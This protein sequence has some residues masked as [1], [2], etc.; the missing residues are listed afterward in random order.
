MIAM[1]IHDPA[2]SNPVFFKHLPILYFYNA[3]GII[4]RFSHTWI[5][6][7]VNSTNLKHAVFLICK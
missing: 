4:I 5:F 1:D 3:P 6:S 7:M 2:V